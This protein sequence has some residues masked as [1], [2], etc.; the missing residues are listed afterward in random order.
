MPKK[1]K[2]NPKLNV[3]QTLYC[4]YYVNHPEARNNQT[5][6][7]AM[8]YHKNI[9]AD[10]DKYICTA[11]ASNLMRKPYIRDY[12]RELLQ[13]V[14]A[15][16]EVVDAELTRA[17]YQDSNTPAKVQ[18]IK[19]YNRVNGRVSDDKKV[20]VTHTIVGFNIVGIEGRKKD[21]IS[22]VS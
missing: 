21:E 16:P 12:I 22:L 9:D 7:Y 14:I 15:M 4:E 20:D 19:E 11:A 6:A 2:K 18:A 8:A 5:L 10:E 1:I 13:A 3:C 17:I